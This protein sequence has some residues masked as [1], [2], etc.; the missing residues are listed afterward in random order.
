M[1]DSVKNLFKIYEDMIQ[2]LLALK[3][4]F[5][6]LLRIRRLNICS[7]LLFPALKAAGSSADC[8]AT[9]LHIVVF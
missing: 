8:T 3:V 1:P 7:V 9:E 2:V 4:V 5:F 6:F